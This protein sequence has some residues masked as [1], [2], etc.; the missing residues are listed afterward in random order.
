MRFKT[1]NLIE[2]AQPIL[3]WTDTVIEY[4]KAGFDAFDLTFTCFYSY[5][6][7][8]STYTERPETLAGFKDWNDVARHLKKV[9][10]DYGIVC[11][12]THAPFP[13][14]NKDIRGTFK[15]ALEASAEAGAKHCVIHPDNDASAEQNAEM[16]FELL[17]VAKACDVKICTENMWNWPK[18]SEYC[19]PAACSTPESFIKHIDIVNDPYLV[20]CLDIGHAE[21]KGSTTSAVE[22]IHALGK[23]LECLHVHDNDK[24]LDSHELPFTMD[25]DFVPIMQAL[26]DIGYNG[27]LTLEA[28]QHKNN[29]TREETIEIIK[30]AA[31]SATRLNDIYESLK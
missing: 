26:K 13:S 19:T 30:K 1:S 29:G 21:M 25:I 22:L 17:P 4:A 16:Y 5:D 8:T 12:Q 14:C 23:R 27:W 20:A 31:A 24:R 6:W 18:G 11:N 9:A 15:R 3:G 7:E 10:S 28:W 2:H